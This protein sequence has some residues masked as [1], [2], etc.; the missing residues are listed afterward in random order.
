[1]TRAEQF[2]HE[3]Y[4]LEQ[5]EKLEEAFEKYGQAAALNDTDA[6]IGIA[7]L[8]LSGKFRPIEHNGLS[9]AL[10]SGM[11]VFPRNLRSE[12]RP[13]PQNALKWLIRA[14]DLGNLQAC[15][16]AG[17]MLCS[18]FGCKA[19]TD[20]GIPYLEKA[21]ASGHA[22]ARNSLC[23]F[24]PDGR[25]LTDEEY[26]DCLSEFER[27]ADAGDDRAYALYATLK[28]GS[29]K[30]LARLGKLLVTAQNMHR[31]GYAEFRYSFS[32][33][34]IPL[35]PVAARR[36]AW[37]TFLRFNLDAWADKQPLIAVA[38][39]ILDPEHPHLLGPLCCGEIVGTASYR[40]PE[41]GWL[42]KEKHAV[43]IRLGVS[44]SLP[45]ETLNRVVSD[46]QLADEEY[47]G[48]S[49]A[50]MVEHGEKEY[51]FEVA[52]IEGGRVDVL[53]RY[54]IGGSD[55]VRYYFT[56][57]LVSMELKE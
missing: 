5:Q 8:Y 53:W 6:M 2:Y 30:Q 33:S 36:G 19:D 50:F 52:S 4:E 32:P 23:L 20:K 40:S 51:S 3:G 35:I 47:Q 12:M 21:A 27:A 45:G 34:G 42:G 16:V 24:R 54:T 55:Q 26:E 46:F 10:R 13:D 1:M 15:D 29:Q 17:R 38:S 14:A 41:F 49:V 31:E 43:L 11:P 7:R 44:A 18:G 9:E 48:D 25:Q 56:P 22:P 57:E 37:Q 39:D 28:S